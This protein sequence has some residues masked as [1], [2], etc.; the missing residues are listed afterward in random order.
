MPRVD[1]TDVGTPDPAHSSSYTILLTISAN[2]KFLEKDEKSVNQKENFLVD[3]HPRMLKW[4]FNLY[5]IRL[6]DV[7]TKYNPNE[8]WY[9]EMILQDS[10]G[11]WL[12]AVLLGS[13]VKRWGK[14]LK[15]FHLFNM[16]CDS[17]C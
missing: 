10:K 3:V 7:M 17:A 5:V 13:L 15:E 8:L 11:E 14:V 6:W 2:P 16:R 9:V 4:N 1:L 12:H